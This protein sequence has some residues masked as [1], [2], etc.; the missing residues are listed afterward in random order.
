MH[1]RTNASQSDVAKQASISSLNK[2]FFTNSENFSCISYIK[3]ISFMK[4]W[5]FT[6]IAPHE[7][8]TPEKFINPDWGYELTDH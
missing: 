2:F 3:N 5:G 6:I 1:S 7:N 4:K 8:V